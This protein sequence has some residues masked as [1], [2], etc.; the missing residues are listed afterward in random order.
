M[1]NTLDQFTKGE[2]VEAHPATDAWMMGDR[3]GT[4]HKIGHKYVHVLMD[5]SG[6]VRFFTPKNLM[7]V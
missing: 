5:R 1:T 6:R 2:R 3:Y 7:K 4:V